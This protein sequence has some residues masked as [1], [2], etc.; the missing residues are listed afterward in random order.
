[1]SSSQ[2]V[3]LVMV[4]GADGEDDFVDVAEDVAESDG[5]VRDCEENGL[6]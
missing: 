2:A 1:M 5:V 6:R 4:L 3:V